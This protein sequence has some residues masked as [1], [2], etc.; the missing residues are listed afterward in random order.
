MLCQSARFP[1][2]F[3][4]VQLQEVSSQLDLLDEEDRQRAL[5]REAQDKAP[6][7]EIAAISLPGDDATRSVAKTP[8][9]I[10]DAPDRGVIVV[11]DEMG[12]IHSRE[13]FSVSPPLS[14]QSSISWCMCLDGV[15][16]SC[17]CVCAC[18]CVCVAIL[19]INTVKCY[20]A[21]KSMVLHSNNSNVGNALPYYRNPCNALIYNYIKLILYYKL[22]VPWSTVY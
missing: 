17:V 5:D 19:C 1:D 13:S 8:E 9:I 7:N 16:Q 12:S 18:V 3:L 21:L 11:M 6:D 4:F 20:T 14:S 2:C 22:L 15:E 10:P